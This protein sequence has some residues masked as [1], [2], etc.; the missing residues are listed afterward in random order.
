[1]TDTSKQKFDPVQE[2]ITIRDSLT[3]TLGQ[4]LK[5]ASVERNSFPAVNVYETEDAVIVRTQALEGSSASSLEVAVED[6]VLSISGEVAPDEPDNMPINY[7]IQ[8]IPVGTFLRQITLPLA[9]IAED[10]EATLKQGVLR[11]RLPKQ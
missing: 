7:V 5:L 1:M 11:I 9:V 4:S 10:A 3:R 2:F 8:E 6:G